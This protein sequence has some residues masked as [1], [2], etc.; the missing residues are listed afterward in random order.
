MQTLKKRAEFLR[1]RRAPKV[2]SVAFLLVGQARI[3]LSDAQNPELDET[4]GP[5]RF[6]YTVT[7]KLGSA[8]V[9]NRIKRRLRAA[10]AEIGPKYARAG[11]DYNLVAR[12]AAQTRD[13]GALKRDLRWALEKLAKSPK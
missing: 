13:F 5:A 10:V 7:K 4:L 1:L 3:E 11:V 12:S 6:G 2:S 9:R 8:V